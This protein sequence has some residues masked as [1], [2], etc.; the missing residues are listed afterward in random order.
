MTSTNKDQSG[1]NHLYWVADN[2]IANDFPKVSSA[3]SDPDGLLAIGGDLSMQRL[4]CAYKNGIFPWYSEGQPILWWSPDPRCVLQPANLKISRSL[5]R[6]LRK[7]QFQVS[8]NQAFTDVIRACAE[9]RDLESGT[10]IT[11][12]MTQAYLAL[13]KAGYAVSVECW[14]DAKLVGGL[15]GIAIGKV[16]FGESMFSRISDASKVALVNLTQTIS[17]KGFKL[18]DCQVHSSHLQSL[19]AEPMQRELFVDILDKYC[20]DTDTVSWPEGI[21]LA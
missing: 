12:D 2:V 10:W 14:Q 7:K 16:F 15:Y 19:G 8:Y 3:L 13:H 5:A 11:N 1:E 21:Q 18:I 17:D 9:P 20:S 6:T 4:L